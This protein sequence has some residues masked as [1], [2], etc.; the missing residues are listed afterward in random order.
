MR[1]GTLNGFILIPQRD[2]HGHDKQ[3]SERSDTRGHLAERE[4]GHGLGGGRGIV[5]VLFHGLSEV[6]AG[7]FVTLNAHLGSPGIHALLC[8][9]ALGF[10]LEVV[11]L[12]VIAV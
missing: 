2:E 4:E 9:R 7:F 10:L 6:F 12:L 3:G 11:G 8:N 1:C 5:E